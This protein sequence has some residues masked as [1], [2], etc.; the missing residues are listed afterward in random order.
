M[1]LIDTFNAL[2]V[3]LQASPAARDYLQ[4]PQWQAHKRA[5]SEAAITLIRPPVVRPADALRTT[6]DGGKTIPLSTPVNSR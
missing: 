5:V 4:S 2:Q 1:T 6:L 3:L